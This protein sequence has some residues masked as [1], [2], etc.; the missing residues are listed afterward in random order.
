MSFES[1]KECRSNCH[2]QFFRLLMIKS[3]NTPPILKS[4]IEFL[5]HVDLPSLCV[6]GVYHT[7]GTMWAQ[8]QE[9]IPL[10]QPPNPSHS[11]IICLCRKCAR[12]P[13]HLNPDNSNE[14]SFRKSNSRLKHK[15]VPKTH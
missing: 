8:K 13:E 11:K 6:G 5:C 15:C 4:H 10:K 2:N 14:K 7:S 12:V 9:E 3:S 1:W